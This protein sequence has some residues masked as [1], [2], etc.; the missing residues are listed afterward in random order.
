M[1]AP[2]ENPGLTNLTS[3]VRRKMP[4]LYILPNAIPREASGPV[5]KVGYTICQAAADVVGSEKVD[6]SQLFSGVWRLQVKDFR[7]RAELLTNGLSI[8][9]YTIQCL[10]SNPYLVDG[11]ETIQ[12]TIGNI[13]SDG[14]VAIVRRFSR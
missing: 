4:T 6:G 13:P 1:A 9:G 7:A 3:K 12:L 10:G 14:D 5:Y 2:K 11:Q 8:S